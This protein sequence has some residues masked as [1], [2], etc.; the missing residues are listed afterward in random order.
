MLSSQPVHGEHPLPGSIHP[1]FGAVLCKL[2][3]R[4]AKRIPKWHRVTECDRF[5][6]GWGESF[7]LALILGGL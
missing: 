5:L 7:D 1:C 2:L 6:H 4:S 3:R